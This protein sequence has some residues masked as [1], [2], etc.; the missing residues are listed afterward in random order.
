[1]FIPF[2]DKIE[3]RPFQRKSV[4]QDGSNNFEEYGEVVSVGKDVVFVSPGDTVFF[5]SYGCS[6]TPEVDGVQHYIVPCTSEFIL[7]K[8][9]RET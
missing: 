2:D 6:K 5:M 8:N 7:G 9:V 1:M 3:I 4:I